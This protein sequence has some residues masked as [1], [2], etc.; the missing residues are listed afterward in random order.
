MEAMLDRRQHGQVMDGGGATGL[1]LLRW[2][3]LRPRGGVG[4]GMVASAG[5]IGLRGERIL[6]GCGGGRELAGGE[7][8]IGEGWGWARRK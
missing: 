3:W 8:E 6:A 7:V 1:P 5:A 4:K 2:V